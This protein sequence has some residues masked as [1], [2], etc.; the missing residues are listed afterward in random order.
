MTFPV[1]QR[2][3]F[4]RVPCSTERKTLESATPEEG[5]HS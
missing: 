4:L 5:N 1:E 3:L 2:T